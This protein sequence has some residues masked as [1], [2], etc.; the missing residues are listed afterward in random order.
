MAYVYRYAEPDETRY[1]FRAPRPIAWLICRL[2][3]GQL[4]YALRWF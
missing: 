2:T 3:G 1:L 4:D